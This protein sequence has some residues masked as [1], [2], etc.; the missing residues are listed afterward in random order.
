MKERVMYF[1]AFRMGNAML[2]GTC[3]DGRYHTYICYSR[4]QAG[5]LLDR[6]RWLE[7]PHRERFEFLAQQMYASSTRNNR[8][9]SRE[10][11]RV[12]LTAGSRASP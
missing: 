10:I 7:Q 8:C 9:I 12:R 1:C 3:S 11:R 5:E 6:L 4:R 2:V